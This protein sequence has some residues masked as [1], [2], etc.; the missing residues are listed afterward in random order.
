M[1]VDNVV[2]GSVAVEAG[3]PEIVSAL[4]KTGMTAPV[5]NEKV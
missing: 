3:A 4:T 2:Q 5:L 1:Q